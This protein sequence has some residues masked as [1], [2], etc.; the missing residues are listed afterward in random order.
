MATNA[1]ERFFRERMVTHYDRLMEPLER[2]VFGAARERLVAR[3]EGRVLE[4]GAGTGANFA[5]YGPQ[6]SRVVAVEPELG[7]LAQSRSRAARLGGR[8]HLLAAE[9]EALPFRDGAFDSVLGTLVLCTVDRP[10]VALAE[11]RRVLRP[12]GRLLLLE[13]VRSNWAA[14]GAVQD[15]FTPVQQLLAA[16]CHLNRRTRL[17]VERAGLTV[18]AAR[19]RFASTVVEI[20]AE[21]A[22]ERA[23]VMT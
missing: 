7:M 3:A 21:R 17:L 20:E 8:V 12:G 14:V 19:A 10:A 5:Y 9:G 13:H 2:R 4:I 6:A 18:T 23:G 1:V 15:V 11:V 22:A 16:G